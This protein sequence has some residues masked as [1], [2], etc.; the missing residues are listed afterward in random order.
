[1][2]PLANTLHKSVLKVYYDAFLSFP[3]Q[4]EE[5]L[6]LTLKFFLHTTFRKAAIPIINIPTAS[7]MNVDGKSGITS[8]PFI[9]IVWVVWV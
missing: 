6:L 3:N 9:D 7:S 8:V 2:P 4:K 1:M 5:N